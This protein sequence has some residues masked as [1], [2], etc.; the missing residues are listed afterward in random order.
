MHMYHMLHAF[1]TSRQIIEREQLTGLEID[2][3][4]EIPHT[5][6]SHDCSLVSAAV[7][8]VIKDVEV[9]PKTAVEN[10]EYARGFMRSRAQSSA[11]S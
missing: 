11:E 10:S 5:T 8:L 4:Q 1:P 2:N 9:S 7:I 3:A 6:S